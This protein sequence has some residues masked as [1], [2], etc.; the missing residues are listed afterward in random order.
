[1]TT[2]NSETNDGGIDVDRRATLRALGGAAAG[3]SV[4]A[5]AASAG[6]T[7]PLQYAFFGC[8][9]VCVNKK[10]KAKAV[11]WTGEEFRTKYIRERSHRST[12][13]VRDW[14]KVYC[15]EVYD[16][17]AVVGLIHDGTFIENPN[18]CAENYPA[19]D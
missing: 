19:Y 6:S 11:V 18:R 15:Y 1:M 7:S 13:D 17:D 9:Q 16:G 14:M 12:P 10:K 4:L 2:D 5:G 3:L 8:S